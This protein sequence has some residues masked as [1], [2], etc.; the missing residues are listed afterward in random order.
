[1]RT[2]NYI[3]LGIFILIS[4]LGPTVYGGN[5]E[6]RFTEY[7]ADCTNSKYYVDLEIKATATGDNF[8]LGR[9]QIQF[10]FNSNTIDLPVI[11]QELTLSGT[12][13]TTIPVTN[14]TYATHYLSGSM[15]NTIVYNVD[16]VSGD[17]YP[18]DHQSWIPIGRL[19]FDLVDPLLCADLTFDLVNVEEVT[20]TGPLA[21]PVD[22]Y[23]LPA[24][25][26]I[27]LSAWLEGPYILATGNMKTTLND[28]GLLP[29]QTPN[30]PSGVATP[31]G[32]PF[33]SA[34]FNYSGTESVIDYPS[35][36]VDWILVEL[37]TAPQL[38]TT[39][40]QQA[41]LLHRDGSI[42]FP[43]DKPISNFSGQ[44]VYIVVKH[45][46]HLGIMTPTLTNFSCR[47]YDFDFRTQ[48]SYEDT[49]AF[50]QKELSPGVFSLYA[51]DFVAN[52]DI[53]GSDNII[54]KMENGTFNKYLFSDA[55][56]DGDCNL[57]DIILWSR[58]N[59]IFTTVEQ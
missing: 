41:G 14:T 4:L 39:F 56:L 40:H 28:Y 48:P 32:Q 46:N 38:A 10:S 54:W 20:S 9:Q 58:N 44:S 19:A 18:V 22:Y 27:N 31:A 6:I 57:K 33:N 50:G 36:V 2:N 55:N 51:G 3:Q 17:G 53:N 34:P 16:L 52:G 1:M 35:D 12:V 26:G 37:R 5:A 43:E 49:G 15:G 21:I 29:G 59:G 7:Q 24:C 11:D 23:D 45:R 13:Q 42:T 47:T 30:Q 8:F 25:P